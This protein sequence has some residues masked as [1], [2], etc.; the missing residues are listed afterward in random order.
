MSIVRTPAMS[1]LCI[2]LY[3]YLSPYVYSPLGLLGFI[4]ILQVRKLSFGDLGHS[5]NDGNV[6]EGSLH[7][8]H[9]LE[10]MTP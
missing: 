2:A 3:I 7:A 6:F 8:Q 10:L 1:S 9:E 4:P 5:H